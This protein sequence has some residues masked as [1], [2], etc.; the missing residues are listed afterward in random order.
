MKKHLF[1]LAFA[2]MAFSFNVEAQNTVSTI[3]D[4]LEHFQRGDINEVVDGTVRE[5]SDGS[6]EVLAPG[7]TLTLT[8]GE[9]ADLKGKFYSSEGAGVIITDLIG[10]IAENVIEW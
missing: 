8:A 9:F 3:D 4:I 10:I 5:L 6:A 2:L 7:V 1:L